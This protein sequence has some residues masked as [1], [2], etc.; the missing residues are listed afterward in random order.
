M[1]ENR[2]GKKETII[3]LYYFKTSNFYS[4]WNWREQN[5]V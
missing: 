3:Y 4:T 5:L 2:I 1:E